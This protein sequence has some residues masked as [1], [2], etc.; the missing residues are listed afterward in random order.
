V[1]VAE[2][3]NPIF[4]ALMVIVFVPVSCMKGMISRSTFEYGGLGEAEG[5]D[6]E[7]VNVGA[8]A[9]RKTVWLNPFTGVMTIE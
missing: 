5:R 6:I 1:Q 3:S 2:T 9:D 4:F 8:E 7:P